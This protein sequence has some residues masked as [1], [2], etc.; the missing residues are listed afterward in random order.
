MLGVAWE[1]SAGV[2][3]TMKLY[4]TRT[5]PYARI[6]RMMVLEKG[7]EG[8]VEII[9]ARTRIAD[10]PYYA[11]NPSGR[12]PYLIRDDGTG[13]EESSLICAWLD[14][15]DGLP[16]FDPPEG[17]EGWELRRLDAL[18]RSFLDGLSVWGRELSRPEG[19]RSPTI[20]RHERQ[21]S[22]RLT[23][24]WEREIDASLM[25]GPLNMAQMTL[26]A[27]LHPEGRHTQFRWRAGHP[28]LAAWTDRMAERPSVAATAPPPSA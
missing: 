24:L 9:A 1:T 5:S 12:V 16:A 10:S 15:L 27:A 18:A 28:K 26:A 20:I 13:L 3:R 2:P 25:G 7:L 21:R 19:D 14:H 22:R 17:P 8:R 11:I 4:I 23:G 6:A